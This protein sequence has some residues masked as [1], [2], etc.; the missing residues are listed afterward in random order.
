MISPNVSD[1]KE[2]LI[3]DIIK[4]KRKTSEVAI[5]LRVSIR[6]IQKWVC[7]YEYDGIQGL[8]RSKP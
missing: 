8:I 5:I 2:H 4:K 7:R 1:V 6:T 3:Q